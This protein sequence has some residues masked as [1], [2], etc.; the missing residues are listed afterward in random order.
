MTIPGDALPEPVK[1]LQIVSILPLKQ[2]VTVPLAAEIVVKQPAPNMPVA[3]GVC[4]PSGSTAGHPQ[5]NG[6]Y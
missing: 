4:M 6:D 3:L 1:V 5:F 2:P